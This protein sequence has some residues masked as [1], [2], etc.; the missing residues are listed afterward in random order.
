MTLIASKRFQQGIFEALASQN[1]AAGSGGGS[2]FVVM[3]TIAT[4]GTIPQTLGIAGSASAVL[5]P[6]SAAKFIV[7]RAA[8]FL[9]NATITA[10]VAGIIGSE[11]LGIYLDGVFQGVA[12]S[13]FI[14]SA[15]AGTIGQV[16]SMAVMPVLNFQAPGSHTVDWRMVPSSVGATL[17]IYTGIINVFQ[18]GG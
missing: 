2:G 3:Q 7:N 17:D 1:R 18:L 6:G 8:S 11:Q 10:D 14:G 12:A 13:V 15:P 5:I 9:I 16:A 4:S